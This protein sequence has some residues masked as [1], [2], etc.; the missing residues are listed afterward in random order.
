MQH[1]SHKMPDP[2]GQSSPSRGS[3]ARRRNPSG[4][5]SL[6]AFGPFT[7]SQQRLYFVPERQG[8][9]RFRGNGDGN[10][11]VCASESS[12]TVTTDGLGYDCTPFGAMNARRASA[13]SEEKSVSRCFANALASLWRTG[14]IVMLTR[15]FIHTPCVGRVSCDH[16]ITRKGPT[17]R[18]LRA[19]GSASIR[20]WGAQSDRPS[21]VT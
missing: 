6:S 16:C 15:R 12:P 10:A 19:R 5:G 9:A 8:Q 21:L 1:T 14:P 7:A 3:R 2:Q 4:T 11:F 13:T 20:I 18:A 17:P